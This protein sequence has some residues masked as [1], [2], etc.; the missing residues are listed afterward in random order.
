[1]LKEIVET[2]SLAAK[3]SAAVYFQSDG[4]SE[5]RACGVLALHRS[6]KHQQPGD[7]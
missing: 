7:G 5:R 2:V 6:T 4:V 1:M 3:R